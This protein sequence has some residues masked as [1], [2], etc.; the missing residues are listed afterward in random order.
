MNTHRLAEERSLALHRAVA[1]VLRRDP[2]R[3]G[4]ARDRVQKWRA[5]GLM[6]PYYAERWTCLLD[7]PLEELLRALVDESEDARALRQSTPF[8]GFVEPRVRWKIWREVR[9]RMTGE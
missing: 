8:T 3:L 7:G 6:H 2:V 5:E 4:E 1:D 9:E